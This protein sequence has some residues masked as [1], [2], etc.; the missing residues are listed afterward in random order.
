MFERLGLS[1]KAPARLTVSL[2]TFVESPVNRNP[3][4]LGLALYQGN[5]ADLLREPRPACSSPFAHS[6]ATHGNDRTFVRSHVRKATTGS[7]D[8]AGTHPFRRELGAPP[9]RLHSTAACNAVV[10]NSSW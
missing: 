1:S 2:D 4:G 8:L 5:D 7:V 3:D 9:I 6:V 10:R